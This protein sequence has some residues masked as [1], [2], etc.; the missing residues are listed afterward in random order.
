MNLHLQS[1]WI[2]SRSGLGSC[3]GTGFQKA[4]QSHPLALRQ[5]RIY[6]LQLV[7]TKFIN[8]ISSKPSTLW[9]CSIHC[10][11]GFSFDVKIC[12][13][14][15]PEIVF[16]HLGMLKHWHTQQESS[17]KMHPRKTHCSSSLR[18]QEVI[19][20]PPSYLCAFVG[21][22]RWG[23]TA[24]KCYTHILAGWAKILSQNVQSAAST[25]SLGFVSDETSLVCLLKGQSPYSKTTLSSLLI[26]MKIRKM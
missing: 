13:C 12:S 21:S 19:F 16:S 18:Q 4:S 17:N 9:L 25:S 8:Q 10:R 2:G 26:L 5:H 15:Y 3:F 20:L 23:Q 11:F 22:H 14:G 6:S 1:L 7:V 24:S